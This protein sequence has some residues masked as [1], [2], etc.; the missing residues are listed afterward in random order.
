MFLTVLF[1]GWLL[2]AFF[3][4]TGL[5]D[6][7]FTYVIKCLMSCVTVVNWGWLPSLA[8]SHL[9]SFPKCVIFPPTSPS[10]SRVH[11]PSLA[12]PLPQ[13]KCAGP[14]KLRYN[15]TPWAKLSRTQGASDNREATQTWARLRDTYVIFRVA[16]SKAL[17]PLDFVLHW[18]LSYWFILLWRK[19]S[20]RVM[21]SSLWLLIKTDQG[22][23]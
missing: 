4:V 19:T 22:S 11:W 2:V 14:H 16:Q 6:D 20:P 5:N 3:L 7:L 23:G 9:E 21:T 15:L 8:E 12:H 13:W 17:Y 1:R 10:Y 18:A